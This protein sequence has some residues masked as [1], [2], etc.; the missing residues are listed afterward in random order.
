MRTFLIVLLLTQNLFSCAADVTARQN[1]WA[2]PVTGTSLSNFYQVAPQ[3]YRSEQPDSK[4]FKEL[5]AFGIK[6]VLSLRDHHKDDEEG[7][8]ET[9]LILYQVE[10]SASS[11]SVDNVIAALRI[12]R[13]SPKPILIHCRHGADRTGCICAMYRVVFQNWSKED[14]IDEMENGGFGFH[15]WMFKNIPELIRSADIEVIKKAME[16]P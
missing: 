14:A 13:D 5:E 1:S 2:Q 8:K 6:S 16:K 7:A 4:S 10:T 9:S 11:I 15:G 3:I 12:I